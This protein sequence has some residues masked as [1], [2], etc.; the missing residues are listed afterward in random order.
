MAIIFDSYIFKPYPEYILYEEKNKFFS[1]KNPYKIHYCRCI[2][3]LLLDRPTHL[4][5]STHSLAYVVYEYFVAFPRSA[6]I[7]ATMYYVFSNGFPIS[8]HKYQ[9]VYV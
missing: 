8:L 1:I 4:G 3:R 5:L 7:Y 6:I 2:S 9:Y